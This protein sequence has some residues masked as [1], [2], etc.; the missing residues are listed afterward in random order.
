MGASALP[1]APAAEPPYRALVE[2][3]AGLI[4]THDLS[5]ILL[6]V[7]R[8]AAERLGYAAE[9]LIGCSLRDLLAASVRDQF[10]QYL[11]RIAAAPRDE[12]LMLVV[13]RTGEEP[14]WRAGS[15]AAVMAGPPATARPCRSWAPSWRL[16]S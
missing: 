16:P 8:A 7:N 15:G 1:L 3:G 10:P 5:G 12:G 2:A 6:S 9:E 4:C 13:T 14:S 11:A